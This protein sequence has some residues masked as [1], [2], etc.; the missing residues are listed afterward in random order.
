MLIRITT[1]LFLILSFHLPG[2]TLEDVVVSG[3]E[4]MEDGPNGEKLIWTL[5]ELMVEFYPNS[6]ALD[7]GFLQIRFILTPVTEP[8]AIAPDWNLSA[9]PNPLGNG[10]LQVSAST[11]VQLV[12]YDAL[13]HELERAACPGS[14]IALEFSQHP[15]GHYWLRAADKNGLGRTIQIQKL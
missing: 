7:Q 3:A 2:Q 15:A 10:Q 9:W 11:N 5:G 6:Q 14:I 8:D 4:T 13:G 12:L 1:C